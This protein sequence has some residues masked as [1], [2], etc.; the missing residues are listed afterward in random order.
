MDILD[1]FFSI[2]VIILFYL[3]VQEEEG[4]F[5]RGSS[6]G[7]SGFWMEHLVWKRCLKVSLPCVL[8]SCVRSAWFVLLI[9]I[10]SWVNRAGSAAIVCMYALC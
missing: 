3:L 7:V 2:L 10:V 8:A 9:Q 5:H 1:L 4:C 6:M